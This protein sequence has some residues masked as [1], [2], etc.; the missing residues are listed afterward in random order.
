MLLSLALISV[1]ALVYEL[2]VQIDQGPKAYFNAGLDVLL[3][4]FALHELR[5]GAR[6]EFAAVFLGVIY[7]GLSAYGFFSGYQLSNFSPSITLAML[8]LVGLVY[9]ATRDRLT[10]WP[11]YSFSAF[12]AAYTITATLMTDMSSN[13]R[14]GF[15]IMGI[16]GQMIVFAMIHRVIVK[17]HETLDAQSTQARI[18]RALAQCS[19]ALLSRG[20]AEP[21]TTALSA[22]LGATDAS[23]AYIDVNRDGPDGTAHWEI[24]ADARG[25]DYPDREPTM[26]SGDY[27]EMKGA[28][29][30]LRAGRP[31][32]VVPAQLVEPLRS[33]Y[34]E[35]G[36]KAELMAPIRIGERWV[37]CIGYTDLVREGNWSQAEIEGLMRA[38]DMVGA[39]WQREAAREGL[40]E[41]AQ[42]K[43]R[44]IAAVSHELRTPLAAV[45][46][47]AGELAR[48]A[49]QYTADELA[50]MADFV[51]SQSLELTELVNDLL[52]AERAAS[53]NLTIT[54][55]DVKLLEECH[56]TVG[57]IL[58]ASPIEVSGVEV[59]AR[60]DGLR[61]RQIL[62]NLITNAVRYGGEIIEVEV[63]AEEAMARVTVRDNGAGVK[64]IDGERIFDAY[65]RASEAES[66]PDSVGLGLSVARQ[67]ARLMEGDLVYRRRDGWTEFELTLPLGEMP[68]LMESTSS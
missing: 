51:Y 45:M 64:G 16:P 27:A 37:G 19:E 32:R 24:I 40:M 52:T 61:T 4:A 13:D 20:A 1:A 63:A 15:I 28:E 66:K 2:T 57:A 14:L 43:D 42:A 7:G 54:T 59:A 47:F 33:Q 48:N 53:G 30:L 35:S 17:L 11:L 49:D 3:V 31:A 21:L 46:G 26:T 10:T 68:V 38:A 39:Y 25:A 12:I 65:Y 62:R 56:R 9:I 36:V 18:Q 6:T 34:E 5:H 58:E 55:G 29:A 22:L 23:Y 50:E 8:I 41:L 60:A 44:F 67:L